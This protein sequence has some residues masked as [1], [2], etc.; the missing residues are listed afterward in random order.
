MDQ[1]APEWLRTLV[2][3]FSDKAVF[4]HFWGKE[5]KPQLT[6]RGV[7]P[8]MLDPIKA[9]GAARLVGIHTRPPGGISANAKIDWS[10]GEGHAVLSALNRLVHDLDRAT[11]SA[12]GSAD[13]SDHTAQP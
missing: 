11:G 4:W 2:A 7:T 6:K 10:E 5:W 12:H 9:Q 8:D 1:E 3:G 13:G